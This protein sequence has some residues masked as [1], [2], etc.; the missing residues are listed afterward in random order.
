MDILYA[1]VASTRLTWCWFFE[2][3]TATILM[4]LLDL[5]VLVIRVNRKLRFGDSIHA[6]LESALT[7]IMLYGAIVGRSLYMSTYIS[8]K[9]IKLSLFGLITF[10]SFVA[11][12][13]VPDVISYKLKLRAGNAWYMTKLSVAVLIDAYSLYTVFMCYIA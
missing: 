12:E 13:Y 11:P 5:S 10:T 2:P 4:G 1:I 8:Y 6:L 7:S 9:V 3:T